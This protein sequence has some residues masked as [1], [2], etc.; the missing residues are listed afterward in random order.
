MMNKSRFILE[1]S[2]LTPS[3]ARVDLG[4]CALFGASWDWGR[5]CAECITL[6]PRT[7]VRTCRSRRSN[8]RREEHELTMLPSLW[9]GLMVLCSESRWTGSSEVVL[10]W[11]RI[12]VIPLLAPPASL[13]TSTLN[14]LLNTRRA[15]P[16]RQQLGLGKRVGRLCAL[17]RERECGYGE[18]GG[19]RWDG[20]KGVGGI[21]GG[22]AVAGG[23]R[24][25]RAWNDGH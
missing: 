21:R 10:L 18:G 3:S 24:A 8:V 15:S 5:Q 1:G 9:T 20:A 22:F 6:I 14:P 4:S 7:F 23:L 19:W 16:H 12:W 17:R 2:N 25:G 11:N 13:R